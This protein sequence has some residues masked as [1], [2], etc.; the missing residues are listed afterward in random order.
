M[1]KL[2]VLSILLASLSSSFAELTASHTAA[3]EK[4]G[5]RTPIGSILSS[6]EWADVPLALRERAHWLAV[7]PHLAQPLAFVV[8]AWRALDVPFYGAGLKAYE[9]LAGARSLGRT[10]WLS[11]AE[12][13]RA[14]PTVSRRS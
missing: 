4:L 6:A 5:A 2:L 8:P 13:R 1:K 7:A 10:R 11:A 3:V 14:L 12:T 9:L